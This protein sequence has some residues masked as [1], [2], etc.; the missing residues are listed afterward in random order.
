MRTIHLSLPLMRRLLIAFVVLLLGLAISASAQPPPGQVES[1]VTSAG[2][3]GVYSVAGDLDHPWGMAFLPDGRM[4]VTE[5]P[6][7]LRIVDS[8]FVSTP[9][10]GTPTVYAQDQGGL[11]DVALDPDFGDNAYVYLS[12]A[13]PGPAGEAATA[14]GRA[15]WVAGADSLAGWED[16]FV[17]EPYIESGAHFGSRLAFTPDGHL[18]ITTGERFQ[19]S[20]AQ[21]LSTHFGKVIR[22]N[23]DGSVP[24]DNPFVGQ[25][26]A[27]PEIW[28]YGHRNVQAVAVD[29]S[30]DALYVV[31]MGPLGG[32]ELNRIERGAN[33]GWPV[34]S[35]GMNYDGTPIPD[36]P[37]RPEFT[38]AVKQWTPVISP[39]GMVFYTGGVYDGWDGSAVIGSLSQMGIVRVEIEGGEVVDEEI[40]VLGAR[41]RD[42]E[43]GPDG[44]VY[45]LTDASDGAV[46]RLAPLPTD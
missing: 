41:I 10:M 18:V 24:D 28:S 43:Q 11:L 32:D 46:W 19:F 40:L 15:R 20:P 42:V 2:P 45:V 22:I 39:N 33:Y 14:V 7:R 34:V 21:D 29:P 3:V 16:L 38:D 37:T 13:K 5:R 25:S 27:Q 8:S 1:I 6:G 17:Q 35:W 44:S 12:Y 30:T 4:L 31:E 36:P 23:R 26:G 9:V